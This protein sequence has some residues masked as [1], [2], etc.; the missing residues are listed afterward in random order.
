MAR[1][2]LFLTFVLFL[3]VAIA[4]D[5]RV[6]AIKNDTSL[7]FVDKFDRVLEIAR[8]FSEDPPN[9]A[10]LSLTTSL[11]MDWA[12]SGDLSK[13]S[14][15]S[16]AQWLE[17]TL[18]AL[19][20]LGQANR[21]ANYFSKHPQ[22]KKLIPDES[23]PRLVYVICR[24]YSETGQFS[25]CDK[26][27]AQAK[28][29]LKGYT[30]SLKLDKAKNQ[31][32]QGRIEEA[33]T[34]VNQVCADAEKTN[35]QSIV[36][37]TYGV[38]VALQIQLN[39]LDEARKTLES[40]R[41][42]LAKTNQNPWFNAAYVP[43]LD[44]SLLIHEGKYNEARKVLNQLRSSLVNSSGGVPTV[45]L[46]WTDFYLLT[47]AALSKDAAGVNQYHQYLKTDLA[48]LPSAQHIGIFADAIAGAAAGQ[49]TAKTLEP[50]YRQL[51]SRHP[52]LQDTERLIARIKAAKI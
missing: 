32:F 18:D 49:P 47:I 33:L 34:V 24:Y 4:E 21:I 26:E 8:K 27:L 1:L 19:P 52:D 17:L 36:P 9:V 20:K 35:D 41:K 12:M 42:K 11:L 43:R 50:A 6:L 23:L 40:Y 31:Y 16:R 51:G 46:A 29:R 48:T 15:Q 44:G 28:S 30:P 38:A 13:V 45:H 25:K 22:I 5:A 3:N 10:D 2:H 7:S 14:T 39:R 37:W